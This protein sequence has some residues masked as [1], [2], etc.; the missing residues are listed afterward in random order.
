VTR[1]HLRAV[2]SQLARWDAPGFRAQPHHLGGAAGRAA[3]R[4]VP[5]LAQAAGGKRT[6]ADAVAR[7]RAAQNLDQ[8]RD[9]VVGFRVDDEA[10]IGPRAEQV[11]EADD[12]LLAIDPHVV[13]LRPVARH[14]G[15][16]VVGQAVQVLVVEDHG[17]AVAGRADIG[18]DAAVAEVHGVFKGDHGVLGVLGRAAPVGDGNRALEPQER[19]HRSAAAPGTCSA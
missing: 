14:Q 3:R 19:R 5:D 10:E 11:V 17:H 18:L 1:R 15:S 13:K 12:G 2:G 4:L 6:D 9:D 7:V 16:G 8:R